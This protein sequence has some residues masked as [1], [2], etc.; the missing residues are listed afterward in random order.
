MVKKIDLSDVTFLFPMR[1]DTID[2]LE[3]LIE[4]I[5]FIKTNIETNIH[6]IEASAYHNRLLS[7]LMPETITYT[8]IEDYDTIFYRTKYI[9]QLV[10]NACTD[11]VAVWDGDVIVPVTQ[12]EGS[13]QL[14]RDGSADFVFPYRDRFLDTSE[15][16]R[17]LYIQKRDLSILKENEGKMIPLYAPDPVGGGFFANRKKYIE[18]G[19]ENLS[20]YGWGKEDGERVNRWEILGYKVTRVEGPLYH[21]SHGRGI[22]SKF[23]SILQGKIKN[24]ELERLA[25]MSKDDME[26]EIHTW[27]H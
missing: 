24:Y 1:I 20:F 25:M 16:V 8:F 22:N 7:Q 19:I 17:E 2:R 15:I 18:S 21:L 26:E 3:N 12:M 11:I 13:V 10:E 23:H 5:H 4:V 6:I 14:I 9:N 27:I